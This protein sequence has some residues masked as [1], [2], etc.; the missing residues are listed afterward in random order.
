MNMGTFLSYLIPRIPM[1][2]L[3]RIVC[4]FA[5]FGIYRLAVKIKER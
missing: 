5:G 1:T 2:L 4:T 3:D